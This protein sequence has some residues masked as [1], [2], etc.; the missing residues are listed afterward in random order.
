MLLKRI[1]H[2]LSPLTPQQVKANSKDPKYHGPDFIHSIHVPRSSFAWE[3][4][5]VDSKSTTEPHL[6]KVYDLLS[7]SVENNQ[8]INIYI[9]NTFADLSGYK[10]D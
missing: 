1:E 10:V 9:A 7:L 8:D 5:G 3:V 6:T 2:F 4:L